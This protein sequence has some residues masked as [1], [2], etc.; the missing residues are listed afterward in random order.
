MRA[1]ISIGGLLPSN[2]SRMRADSGLAIS[3]ACSI[4]SIGPRQHSLSIRPI[5]LFPA[6]L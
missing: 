5:A 3:L 6:S 2:W 4:D 1:G